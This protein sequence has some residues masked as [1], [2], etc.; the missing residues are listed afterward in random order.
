MQ[1]IVDIDICIVTSNIHLPCDTELLGRIR[2]TIEDLYKINKT[3]C[4]NWADDDTAVKE[5]AKPYLTKEQI[6]GDPTGV[7]GVVEITEL[8][9]AKLA[10]QDVAMN[11]LAS[12]VNFRCWLGKGDKCTG[13]IAL[14]IKD[15][16]PCR[17]IRKESAIERAK[18]IIANGKYSGYNPNNHSIQDD[19]DKEGTGDE[20]QL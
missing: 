13:C 10:E 3:L 7:A 14:T 15:K 17:K 12:Y 5:L 18:K 8:L 2:Q 1:A 19:D 9:C 6:E 16:F 4:E 11:V 20:V